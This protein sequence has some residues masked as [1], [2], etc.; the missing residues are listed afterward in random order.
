M[1]YVFII[2]S[3]WCLCQTETQTVRKNSLAEQKIQINI[4]ITLRIIEIT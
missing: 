4:G 2:N 1:I 3:R